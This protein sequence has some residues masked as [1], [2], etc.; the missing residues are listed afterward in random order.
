ST[1]TDSFRYAACAFQRHIH[2]PRQFAAGAQVTG[3]CG[4]P[5]VIVESRLRGYAPNVHHRDGFVHPIED[6]R[7]VDSMLVE[8]LFPTVNTMMITAN[9]KIRRGTD[10]QP[11]D[12][13]GPETQPS[14]PQRMTA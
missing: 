9:E 8:A 10:H 4:V 14:L 11:A 6:V 7:P 12:P 3:F 1:R 13:A 5:A 2:A